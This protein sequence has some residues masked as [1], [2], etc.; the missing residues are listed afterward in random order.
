MPNA[1]RDKGLQAER[2]VAR[3]FRQAGLLGAERSVSTG[4]RNSARTTADAGDLKGTPGLAVQIKNI[5]KPLVGDAL[6]KAMADTAA[7]CDAAGAA[8]PL[9]IEKRHGHANPGQWWAWLPANMFCGLAFGIDPY[10]G[11]WAD[12]APP[13]R[14]ELQYIIEPLVRFSQ[15]CGSEAA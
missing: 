12:Y 3:Y 1:N 14:I 13:V 6:A 5:S 2:D 8:I 15:L 7:Q 10:S 9:L 11:T 4:W